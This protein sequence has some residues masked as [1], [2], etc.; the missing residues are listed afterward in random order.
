MPTQVEKKTVIMESEI[1]KKNINQSSSSFI[2]YDKLLESFECC[3]CGAVLFLSKFLSSEIVNFSNGNDDDNECVGENEACNTTNASSKEKFLSCPHNYIFKLSPK[4]SAINENS[5]DFQKRK[6]DLLYSDDITTFESLMVKIK[7][8]LK[9]LTKKLNMVN[10]SNRDERVD[11]LND[12]KKFMENGVVVHFPADEYPTVT[13]TCFSLKIYSLHP[14][15][16]LLLKF[17][18]DMLFSEKGNE[19]Y[20][21]GLRAY[22]M[23]KG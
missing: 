5:V 13:T 6:E 3:S 21:V 8:Y 14:F 7:R 17:H 18:F 19:L 16:F 4:C 2:L 23:I 9:T 11:I 20:E 12:L 10:N 22:E 1:L 15:R